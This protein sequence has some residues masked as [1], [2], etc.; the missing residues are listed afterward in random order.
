MRNS[1]VPSYSVWLLFPFGVEF[2]DAALILNVK[3]LLR[4]GSGMFSQR[5]CVEGLLSRE[6]LEW[7]CTN[8]KKW[9]YW[10]V[11]GSLEMWPP[12]GT[13]RP[14]LS[15]SLLHIDQKVSSLALTHMCCAPNTAKAPEP[16]NQGR[17]LWHY[18][19]KTLCFSYGCNLILFITV[20]GSW[21]DH[22]PF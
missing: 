14:V 7:G 18:I 3:H 20:T 10:Q 2:L 21:L 9:G 15:H 17:N 19:Q 16:T 4:I 8:F 5:P 12:K 13:Q 6:M 1:W 22:R 11:M